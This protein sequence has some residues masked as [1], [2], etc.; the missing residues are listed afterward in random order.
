MAGSLGLASAVGAKATVQ[1]RFCSF[2]SPA[3]RRGGK[4]SHVR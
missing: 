3:S 4:H 1:G 2:Q